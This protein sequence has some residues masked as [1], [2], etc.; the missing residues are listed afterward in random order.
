[1]SAVP[2]ATSNLEPGKDSSKDFDHLQGLSSVGSQ[3]RKPVRLK[4]GGEKISEV[5]SQPEET[6]LRGVSNN[7]G[8]ERKRD[9]HANHIKLQ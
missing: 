7:Q 5:R 9:T 8:G 2:D 6:L 4:K 3:V 1:M